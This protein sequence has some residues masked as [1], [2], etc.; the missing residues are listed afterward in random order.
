MGNISDMG[1]VCVIPCMGNVSDM[2]LVLFH[3]WVMYLIWGLCYS[4]YGQCI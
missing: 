1:L 3:V 2:G 4:M